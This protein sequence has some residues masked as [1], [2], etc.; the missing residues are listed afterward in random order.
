M[1]RRWHPPKPKTPQQELRLQERGRF[2]PPL[3]LATD[4]SRAAAESVGVT[5]GGD[6]P[7]SIGNLAQSMVGVLARHQKRVA[8]GGV[9]LAVQ[10]R[11]EV[12]DWLRAHPEGATADE[13]AA[14][15]NRSILTIRPRVSELNRMKKIIDSTGRRKNASGRNAIV[16]RIA[17]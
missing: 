6:M 9:M 2:T 7:A 11:R 14:A 5:R 16:W 12:F 10:I 4:T 3:K 15:M 8:L 17:E 1:T 13:I